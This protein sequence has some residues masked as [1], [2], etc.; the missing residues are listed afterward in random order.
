MDRWHRFDVLFV[1]VA[2]GMVIFLHLQI[3]GQ[4]AVG[5]HDKIRMKEGVGVEVKGCA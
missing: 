1:Q 2:V 3:A 5:R 4:A